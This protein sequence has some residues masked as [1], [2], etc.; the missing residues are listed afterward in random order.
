MNKIILPAVVALTAL[1]FNLKAAAL[2]LGDSAPPLKVSKWVK[3]GAVNSLESNKTYVVEFWATWRAPTSIPHLT[4]MA[5]T[6]TNITFI[7]VDVWE[8]AED[9]ASK[10]AAVNKFVKQ[11]GDKMDYHVAMDTEEDFMSETWMKAA[12][13]GD[14]PTA[15]L[16]QNGKIIWIGHPMGGLEASLKEASTGKFDMEKAKKRAEAQKKLEAFYEK[17]MQGG[18]EAELAKEGK[19]LEALDKELGGIMPGE[20]LDAQ[21]ILKRA[22]F[23]TAMQAYQKALMGESDEA[24]IAKLEE[25]A[26]ATA[27][28]DVNFDA[29]NKKLKTY[30]TQAKEA[31]KAATL[32]GKYVDAVGENADKDKAADLAKQ[33][34]ALN[35]K[36]PQLLNEFAWAILTDE[37]IKTRDLPLATRLAKTGVDAT[38]GKEPAILDTYARALFDS[39]KVADAVETQKKAVAACEDD[40]MKGELQAT[41]KKYQVAADKAKPAEDKEK[42]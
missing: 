8:Q 4:E 25:A 18:D 7:G 35:I 39:G 13:Q 28:K 27:P 19:E 11:M 5:H 40:S 1:T 32:F 15:F 23:Q 2:G 16:V 34:E 37:N 14:I 38:E 6:Y 30:M 24:E 17:A 9:M 12:G 33:I 21:D 31:Q 41:L 3:G 42:K 29:L 22:K 36:N 10:E 20:T 26:R